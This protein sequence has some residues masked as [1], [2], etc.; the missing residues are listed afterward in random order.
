MS[1]LQLQPP[2][3]FD[4]KSPD[5]WL[6]WKRCFLQ[7]S[8]ASG[9]AGE[10]DTRQV[11]TLLYCLGE[12]AN[13][14]LASIN[15]T[16]EERKRFPKVLETLDEFFKVRRNIIIFERARFN[17]RSQLPGE[18]AEKYIA[19]LYR[20][21]DNCN[22]GN[23]KDE[24]IRDRL[25]VVIQDQNTSQQ[26]QI[27]SDLTVE[28]AKK[29]IRQKEAVREQGRELENQEKMR[30]GAGGAGEDSSRAANLPR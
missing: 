20:L 2:E 18:T 15:I 30:R 12:E 14:V 6:K 19:E 3:P 28:K 4:F 27:D 29:T 9:L 22:Y 16:E 26:L 7:Y 8:D 25:V 10:T 23:L 5:G 13:D 1:T 21:A 24:M 11:S 17:Q